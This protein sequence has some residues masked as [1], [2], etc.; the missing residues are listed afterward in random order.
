MNID[1]DQIQSTGLPNFNFG[2]TPLAFIV[3]ALLTFIFPAAGILVLI[4]LLWGGLQL[5]LSGGDPKAVQSAK[6]KITGALIGF[7]II[8][9]AY[10][11]V[12]I[13][14]AFLGVDKLIDA[15]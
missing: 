1:F 15:F 4:Y 9:A 5:M 6:E 2:N 10:W 13:L 12:Q 11:I 7:V 8:F 14:G 3:S